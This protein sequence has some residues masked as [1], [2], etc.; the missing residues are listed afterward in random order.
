M[1]EFHFGHSGFIDFS[2]FHDFDLSGKVFLFVVE[3]GFIPV[4]GVKKDFISFELLFIAGFLLDDG[5][6]LLLISLNGLS[7]FVDSTLKSL[8]VVEIHLLQIKISIY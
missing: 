1:S 4:F 5:Q 7:E 2:T 6:F 8:F 3:V